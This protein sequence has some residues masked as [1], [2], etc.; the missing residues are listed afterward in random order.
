MAGEK[1]TILPMFSLHCKYNKKLLNICACTGV[2]HVHTHLGE[3]KLVQKLK[4]VSISPEKYNPASFQRQLACLPEK[5]P[6]KHMKSGMR[7][8][9]SRVRVRVCRCVSS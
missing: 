9:R 4:T 3:I 8:R 5:N 7:G 1:S 6:D 2:L